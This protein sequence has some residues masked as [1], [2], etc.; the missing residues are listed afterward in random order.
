M[1]SWFLFFALLVI[2]PFIQ[3]T[4]LNHI[5]LNKLF[6]PSTLGSQIAYWNHQ[7]GPAWKVWGNTQVYKVGDCR[8]ELNVNRGVIESMSLDISS[9]CNPDI[10]GFLASPK[11]IYPYQM[12]FASWDGEGE[13][14]ADCLLM[15]GN[16]E[17]A[18]VHLFIPGFHANNFIDVTLTSNMEEDPTLT[19]A[20]KWEKIMENKEGEDYVIDEKFNCDQKYEHVAEKLLKS[21]PINRITVGVDL[22]AKM[23][24]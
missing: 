21:S 17:A 6:R 24:H 16:A 14:Y 12:T 1:K 11:P 5:H 13:Y 19:Q 23:C 3:A 15:C 18:Y 9:K 4:P 7:I 10:A 20:L 22:S 2:S 8:V